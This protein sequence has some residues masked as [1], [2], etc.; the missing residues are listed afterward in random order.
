M[1]RADCRRHV[2]SKWESLACDPWVY[3][4][5][6]EILLRSSEVEE[7]D[8]SKTVWYASPVTANRRAKSMRVKFAGAP[9]SQR[10][11]YSQVRVQIES[12]SIKGRQVFPSIRGMLRDTLCV[13]IFSDFSRVV[14]AFGLSLDIGNIRESAAET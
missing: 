4:V 1:K 8:N 7:K 6:A 13:K 2:S 14:S 3:S 9:N 5:R 11:G 10:S 12:S